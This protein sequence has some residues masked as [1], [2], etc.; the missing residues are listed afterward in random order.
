MYRCYFV[1][2]A[3]NLW[4]SGAGGGGGSVADIGYCLLHLATPYT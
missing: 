4:K 1:I 3:G 2:V